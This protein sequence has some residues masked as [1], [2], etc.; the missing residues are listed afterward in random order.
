MANKLEL[1]IIWLVAPESVTRL[2]EEDMRHV[3]GLPGSTTAVVGGEV[4]SITWHTHL[5]KAYLTAVRCYLQT[6]HKQIENFGF[7]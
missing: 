4:T 5:L 2:E 6:Q 3:L 7:D 1:S